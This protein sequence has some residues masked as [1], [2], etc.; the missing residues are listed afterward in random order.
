[1]KQF[2]IIN[3]KLIVSANYENGFYIFY[4]LGGLVVAKIKSERLKLPKDI[5]KAWE[6]LKQRFSQDN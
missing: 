4:E 2:F 6:K 3:N 1:M 5:G